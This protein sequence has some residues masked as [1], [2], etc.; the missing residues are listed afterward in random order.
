MAKDFIREYTGLSKREQKIISNSFRAVLKAYRGYR[1]KRSMK[2][3]IYT[4]KEKYTKIGKLRQAYMK[5][6]L[7]NG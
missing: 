6:R 3:K 5:E 7:K 4:D 1:K 2:K